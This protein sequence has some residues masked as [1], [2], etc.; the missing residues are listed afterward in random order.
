LL[1]P[2]VQRVRTAA[3]G[4]SAPTISS[5]SGWR[6]TCTAKNNAGVFRKPPTPPASSSISWIYTLSPYFENVDRIRICPFDPKAANGSMSRG[7]VTSSR[8]Y[9]NV[10]GEDEA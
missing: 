2:A 8:E 3:P 5:R 7:P 6:F 4:R 10:P 9:Y 1:L